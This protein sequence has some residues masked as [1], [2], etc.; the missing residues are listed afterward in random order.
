[1][2]W[3]GRVSET[4]SFH[5]HDTSVAIGPAARAGRVWEAL[6]LRSRRCPPENPGLSALFSGIS[7]AK[8]VGGRWSEGPEWGGAECV[9]W[10][11]LTVSVLISVACP[12]LS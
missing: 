8:V 4:S 6:S 3:H 1:M 10:A 2:G 9:T 11:S 12:V 5:P 7:V